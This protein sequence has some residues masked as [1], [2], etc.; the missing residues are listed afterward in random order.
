MKLFLKKE[1]MLHKHILSSKKFEVIKFLCINLSFMHE[2]FTKVIKFRCI[3]LP[4]IMST[5]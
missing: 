5:L 1:E 4:I 2:S 3:I